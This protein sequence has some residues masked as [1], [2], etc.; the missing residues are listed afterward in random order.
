MWWQL[1]LFISIIIFLLWS[2]VRNLY[3]MGRFISWCV[4]GTRNQVRRNYLKDSYQ[5]TVQ[6][7]QIIFRHKFDDLHEPSGTHNFI[8]SHKRFVDAEYVL[9]DH[10]TLYYITKNDAIFVESAKDKD[11]SISDSGTFL[12]QAQFHLA[13]KLLIMPIHVFLILG[14][15]IGKPKAKL[16]FL[17]NVGRCGSTM[18]TQVFEGCD[19]VMALSEPDSINALTEL[20]RMVSNKEFNQLLISCINLICKPVIRKHINAY[21][22]KPL[23]PSIVLIPDIVASY[24]ESVCVF[25]YRHPLATSRSLSRICYTAPMLQLMM[26]LGQLSARLTK[27]TLQ[28]MGVPSEAF[29]KRLL[30]RLHIGA[31]LWA[32]NVR[33]Y[34]D[35][36]DSGINIVAVRFEDLI[37]D[38]YYAFEKMFEFCGLP[39]DSKAVDRAMSRDSE[40]GTSIGQERTRK[41][42]SYVDEYTDFVK[43]HTD[44]ICDELNVPRFNDYQVLPGTIGCKKDI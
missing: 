27:L 44:K 26:T 18:T 5:G 41:F 2:V 8:A 17:P 32:S 35:F 6:M 15:H 34:L 36:R 12:R 10:V 3:N 39:Y 11:V 43:E 30:F 25:I 42:R 33:Q 24:P 7:L 4:T 19:G 9:Q 31:L 22:V 29:E 20:K 14:E 1:E 16:I 21:V 28:M 40:R 23:E 37:E 13:K 38:R